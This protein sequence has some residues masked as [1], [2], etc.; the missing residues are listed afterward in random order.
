MGSRVDEPL[1]RA[2]PSRGRFRRGARPDEE[3]LLTVAE[4]DAIAARVR[5]SGIGIT[6]V[7]VALQT[8][9]YLVNKFALDDRYAQLRLGNLPD[10]TEPVVWTWMS[11]SAA[12]AGGFAALLLALAVTTRRRTFGALSLTLFYYSFDDAAEVHERVARNVG[13]LGLPADVANMRDFFL[14]APIALVTFVLL[15]AATRIVPSSARGTLSLGLWL[16]VTSVI[17]DEG[18]HVATK[19]IALHG[20]DLP[21]QL[22]L[23]VEEGLE[24]AAVILVATGLATALCVLLRA[25]NSQRVA[26]TQ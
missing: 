23:A 11:A 16:L 17:V 21:E 25:R 2:S 15:W 10:G 4:A 1:R 26:P 3:V 13:N 22:R 7:A 9:A 8:I 20:Y 5:S 19:H 24:L 18:V 12:A 6:V 14:L